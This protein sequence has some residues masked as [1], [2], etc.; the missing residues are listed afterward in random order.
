MVQ[1]AP[2]GRERVNWWVTVPDAG[3]ANLVFSARSGGLQDSATPALGEIPIL[4][5][6]S[7]QTFATSG[8]ITAAGENL[9]VVNLPRSYTPTGGELRVEMSSTLAGAV[10][11][12]LETLENYPFD[13][14]EPVISHLLANL[15]PL[16]WPKKAERAGRI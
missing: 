7:P 5:Y 9:E 15:A 16:T 4:H 14:T 8:L 2:G 6:V 10:L 1:V 13:L 11:S 3:S 12:G